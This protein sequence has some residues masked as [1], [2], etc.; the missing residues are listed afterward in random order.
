MSND[1]IN[2]DFNIKLG[3]FIRTKRE[4]LNISQREFAIRSG[5][6]HATLSRYEGSKNSFTTDVKIS[7]LI[8]L[9]DSLGITLACLIENVVNI[10]S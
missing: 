10:K 6:S 3:T 5:V 7:N 2:E 9:S 1:S 8:K 4:E